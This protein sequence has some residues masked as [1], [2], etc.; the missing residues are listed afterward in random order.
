M[1]ERQNGEITIG[2]DPPSKNSFKITGYIINISPPLSSGLCAKGICLV[3]PIVSCSTTTTSRA[4]CTLDIHLDYNTRYSI[5]L[6]SVNCVGRSIST[7]PLVFRI[8]KED[9]SRKSLQNYQIHT[10]KRVLICN[11][12]LLTL[13]VCP[14]LQGYGTKHPLLLLR[15][16]PMM[17]VM[18]LQHFLW[19]YIICQVHLSL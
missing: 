4:P 17:P 18:L 10:S 9:H 13:F 2:W 15:Y 8:N 3:D 7:E 11:S 1:I 5:T 19:L 16:F 14:Q 12:L 6:Q